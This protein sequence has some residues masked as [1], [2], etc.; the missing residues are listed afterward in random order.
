MELRTLGKPLLQN[1]ILVHVHR[2]SWTQAN[3]RFDFGLG[4]TLKPCKVF[5]G[6]LC[7]KQFI[8]EF[9]GPYLA[10]FVAL[11]RVNVAGAELRK[12]KTVRVLNG[13]AMNFFRS[14]D[15]R[16]SD[17]E[18]ILEVFSSIELI[19]ISH[20]RARMNILESSFQNEIL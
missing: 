2:E 12:E 14:M 15:T 3:V 4:F 1:A 18:K 10:A 9:L 5:Y 7:D 6:Q 20:K 17:V 8:F 13:L 19:K 16:V 11:R